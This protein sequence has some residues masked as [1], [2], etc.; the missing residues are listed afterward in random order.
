[1][2]PEP[3]PLPLPAGLPPRP[4]PLLVC[5]SQ[6][7]PGGLTFW[8]SSGLSLETLRICCASWRLRPERLEAAADWCPARP[9]ASAAARLA[10]WTRE[11]VLSPQQPRALLGLPCGWLTPA[12]WHGRKDMQGQRWLE[13]ISS[14]G[15]VSF[16]GGAGANEVRTDLPHWKAGSGHQSCSPVSSLDHKMTLSLFSHPPPH[17]GT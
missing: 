7:Q 8:I 15:V 14:P 11:L 12:R 1:M 6:H 13:V 10:V 4:L 5:L 17:P 16:F 9:R 3:P 2:R